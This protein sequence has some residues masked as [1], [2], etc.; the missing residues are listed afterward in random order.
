M[1]AHTERP[2]LQIGAGRRHSLYRKVG[3]DGHG[4]FA[5]STLVIRKTHAVPKNETASTATQPAGRP[6]RIVYRPK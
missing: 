2:N 6:V 4:S 3:S 5:R 1:A